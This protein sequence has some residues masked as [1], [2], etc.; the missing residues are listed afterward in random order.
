MAYAL[1]WSP[2]AVEDVESIA[3]WISRDSPH[4]AGTMVHR[5]IAGHPASMKILCGDE[6]SPN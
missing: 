3:A 1:E 4:H 2:E 5:F 6:W